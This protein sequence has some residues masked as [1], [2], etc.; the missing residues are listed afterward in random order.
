M[1]VNPEPVATMKAIVQDTYGA[2]DVLDLREIER[3]AIGDD[4]V[5]VRVHAAG[6][7]PSVWHLM[8]GRPYMV[9]VMGYGLRAPKHPVR[10]LD[11]AGRVENVGANVTRFRTGDDVFG[12]CH[13]SFAEYARVREDRCLPK[14]AG[15]S[16]ESAAAVPV[17]G[18]TAV[19]AVRDK[20]QVQD[21]QH[22]LI[23]GA[24][25][26][27]GTYAVQ[28]AKALGATVT[29]VCSTN[30]TDLVRS[31]GADRVVDYTRSDP[32]DGSRHYDV[33]V[34]CGGNRPLRA[35]RRALTPKGTLVI[36]GGEDGGRLLGGN[37]RLLQAA[38]LSLVV[39]Q[40]LVGVLADENVEDLRYLL[41][42][43]EAGAVT[44]VLDRTFPLIDV[45]DAIRYVQQGH[46]RG[47]VVVTV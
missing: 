35:L 28:I 1:S 17:S 24:A 18:I 37:Q 30:K 11:V 4:E 39:G 29:G 21:G 6:I 20:G 10:G 33:I 13:G 41:D 38:A 25:G 9:R 15:M 26:G 44:P 45:P 14:P 2:A 27:V 43:I 7:D 42:L 34:D 32:V 3:P 19:Q 12:T 8:T 16:F 5:L 23:I 31:I 46:A 47:K 36:V 22:V 40:R